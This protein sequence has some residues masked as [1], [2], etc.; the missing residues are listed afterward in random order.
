MMTYSDLKNLMDNL[1]CDMEDFSHKHRD[2]QEM[3][4]GM[5]V[6]H[7]HD[8]WHKENE[9]KDA[10][11]CADKSMKYALGKIWAEINGGFI[12]TADLCDAECRYVQDIASHETTT[13]IVLAEDLKV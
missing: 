5:N 7:P 2:L 10:E 13:E 1:I 6:E 4:Q 12:S 8:V 3:K 9:V 11:M